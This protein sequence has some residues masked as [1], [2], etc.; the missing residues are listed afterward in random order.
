MSFSGSE[1]VADKNIVFCQYSPWF[2]AK[3]TRD[4]QLELGPETQHFSRTLRNFRKNLQN[5]PQSW[6]FFLFS[7]LAPDMLFFGSELVAAKNIVF[8]KYSPW[9]SAKFTRDD[10]L[11]FG[12]ESQHFSRILEILGKTYKIVQL[13]IFRIFK[14][15]ARYFIF[16][17]WACSGWKYSILR[18]LSVIFS[19]IHLWWPTRILTWISAFQ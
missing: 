4:D 12:P 3:F 1:L 18:I 19:Q 11:E 5:R 13:D 15:G 6:I 8:C 9:F 2:S 16:W 14:I 17:I 7:K 10:Q